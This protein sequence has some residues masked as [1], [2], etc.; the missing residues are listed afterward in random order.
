M[1][2]TNDDRLVDL[3][4]RVVEF[5]DERDWKQFHHPKDIA[6]SLCLEAAE[7]LEWTQWRNGDELRAHLEANREGV[8]EELADVLYWTLLLAHDLEIDLGDAFAAKME[9]NAA[10]YPVDRAR[11]SHRKYTEYE[12]AANDPAED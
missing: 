3:V 5:R 6:L 7:V 12:S 4:G 8:G 11:G 1:A 10:K 2:E 9:K